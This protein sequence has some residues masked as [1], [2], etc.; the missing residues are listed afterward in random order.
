MC[1]G[2]RVYG[3]PYVSVDIKR[4]IIIWIRERENTVGTIRVRGGGSE[5][6]GKRDDGRRRTRKKKKKNKFYISWK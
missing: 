4:S 6:E 3:R 1:G 2:V 5:C